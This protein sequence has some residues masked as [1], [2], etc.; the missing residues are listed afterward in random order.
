MKFRF[1]LPEELRRGAEL[2]S[3]TGYN[4]SAGGDFT[5]T[6]VKKENMYDPDIQKILFS[7]KKG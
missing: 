1:D 4:I 3:E 7:F 6:A 5:V 2:L